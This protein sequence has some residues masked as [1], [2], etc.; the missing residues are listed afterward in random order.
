MGVRGKGAAP[1]A[2]V[3]W[4][5]TLGGQ[6][7]EITLTRASEDGLYLLGVSGQGEHSDE[8]PVS[9]RHVHGDKYLISMGNQS[10]PVFVSRVPEGYRA[11]LYGY[12]FTAQVEE[13]RLYHLK[14]KMAGLGAGAGPSEVVAPMPGLVLAVEVAEGQE[15]AA[16]QGVVVVESMKM[17]NE[18]K[19]T[20]GGVVEKVMVETGQVVD[21]GE[22]LV[23]VVPSQTT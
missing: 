13:A 7:F 11:V 12:E 18:I 3:A 1:V 17:E 6:I 16:G 4:A 20:L 14:H 10:T 2:G 23:R 21:K 15:V 8:T 9:L 19:S 22:T 5:I